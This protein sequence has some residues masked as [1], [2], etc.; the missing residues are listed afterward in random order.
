MRGLDARPLALGLLSAA[1]ALT[2]CGGGGGEPAPPGPAAATLAPPDVPLYVDAV[3][4][5]QGDETQALE[6]ALSKLLATDDP[7]GFI[8]SR[9]DRALAEGNAGITYQDDV[10]PW[11]GERAGAFFET[12]GDDPQGVAVFQVANQ[13]A[14]EQAIDKAAAAD[15][16]P[17]HEATYHGARY[18][19][20]PDGTAVG[21]VGSYLVAG[22]ER[23]FR[24][25]VDASAG[26]SLA[27]ADEFRSLLD[28][29]PD[30]EVAFAYAD[31]QAV[32]S[33]LVR[34]GELTPGQRDSLE[35]QGGALL[36]QPARASL[37]ATPDQLALEVAAG[38]GPADSTPQASPLLSGF[39]DDSWLAFAAGGLAKSYAQAL[40]QIQVGG[41]GTPTIEGL[42]GFDLGTELAHWAGDAGGYLKGT[43]IFGLGGAVVVETIDEQGS[44]TTLRRLRDAL[45]RKP[46]LSV[47]PLEGEEGFSLS[48]KSVPVQFDFVQRE[49]KVV[50]GLGS[51]SVDQ[52]YSPSST[53]GESDGFQ[54][55]ADALGGDFAPALYFDFEPVLELLDGIPDASSDPDYLSA[56][57]YLEHLDYLIAGTRRETDRTSMRLALGLREAPSEESDIDG[58]PAATSLG[59][60]ARSR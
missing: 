14:A 16:A 31:P 45:A 35:Q 41:T 21:F 15:K 53:L 22:T 32:L 54:A 29:A 28:A 59:I 2:G 5:P 10:E 1:A 18:R 37:T 49:G 26:D 9:I 60:A 39:P 58:A 34:A 44:A 51:D 55:A 25:A 52:L 42:L 38:A 6:E 19:V 27:E 36:E 4:R 11:L 46:A 40:D 20:D 47:E 56:K 24:D 48:P 23:G 33:G 50:A 13:A 17:E 57:P 30:G 43:S 7:G 12:L 8:V 3:V